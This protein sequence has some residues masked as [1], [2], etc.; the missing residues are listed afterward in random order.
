MLKRENNGDGVFPLYH[1]DIYVRGLNSKTRSCQLYS[2]QLVFSKT[3]VNH[4]RDGFTWGT[5][6]RFQCQCPASLFIMRL[7]CALSHC[8]Q[9]GKSLEREWRVL[10]PPP[11]SAPSGPGLLPVGHL[12]VLIKKTPNYSEWQSIMMPFLLSV[13]TAQGWNVPL[14]KDALIP[15]FT[16][17]NK[18]QYFTSVCT[19]ILRTIPTIPGPTS[20]SIYEC[21]C[22]LFVNIFFS[23]KKKNKA[24]GDW[25][26]PSSRWCSRQPPMTKKLQR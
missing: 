20:T 17:P 1:F 9:D 7:L 23:K 26:C 14:T 24:K 3:I 16:I 25:R 18:Y 11:P 21:H 15:A 19:L 22:S 12:N 5:W 10:S 13:T 4:Q 2:H 6:H 8:D